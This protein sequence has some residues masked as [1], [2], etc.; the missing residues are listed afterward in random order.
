[1]KTEDA[2]QRT[3][4]RWPASLS[5]SLA[6][7]AASLSYHTSWIGNLGGGSGAPRRLRGALG[8]PGRLRSLETNSTQ[9]PGGTQRPRGPSCRIHRSRLSGE[10]SAQISTS[11]SW[12]S[13]AIKATLCRNLYSVSFGV[14]HLLERYKIQVPETIVSTNVRCNLTLRANS[15]RYNDANFSKCKPQSALWSHYISHGGRGSCWAVLL[16]TRL[17]FWCSF[18]L[19]TVSKAPLTVTFSHISTFLRC[20]LTLH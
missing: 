3:R 15:T 12:D 2:S 1:M 6:A 17:R 10:S 13:S 8:V 9:S 19:G 18:W 14:T 4:S 20:N 16:P 5:S 11:P 7:V